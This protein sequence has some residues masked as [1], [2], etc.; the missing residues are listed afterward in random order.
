MSDEH[1]L[2]SISD[3]DLLRRLSEL[4]K[5]SRRVEAELIAHIAE[6][7]ARRLYAAH[8]SS[9]FSYCTEILHMAEHEAYLRIKA[10]RAS[11]EHPVLIEM[12]ADGRLHLSGIV[13][14][15][16]HLTEANRET[17][18]G[19]AV[20]KTRRQI[21]ELVAELFPKPDVPTTIRKLPERR[22]KTQPTQNEQQVPE[23]VE[24][25]NSETP[26]E[27]PDTG[28]NAEA[29]PAPPATPTVPPATRP[30]VV[31][32]LSKATYK[33]QFTASAKFRDKLERLQALMGSSGN[34]ADLA[35]V[36][37]AAVTEKLEKL[38]A[39]RY[40][41]TKSPRKSL[42]EA[43]TSPSSR[44]ISA[45]VRRAVYARDGGQC[46]YVDP[47]GRRC[48]ETKRLEFHHLEP[49]GKNGDRSVNNVELR[50]R[51]HNFLEAERDYG[52]KIMDR[53]RNSGG[54]VSEPAA[55]YT[56]SNRTTSEAGAAPTKPL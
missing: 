8:A 26:L 31:E 43:D 47:T 46:G 17:L 55:V 24:A 48:T 37:E 56:F 3:D 52:K 15:R 42:E 1:Q 39:K 40:G 49:Y 18:L 5:D 11:R 14:L 33:V 34:D 9:L 53:Y 54:R 38:E 41:K 22:E 19:R 10:A 25:Q 2:K 35:T 23:P 16:P 45:P 6:V 30:A 20:H 29:R 13:V 7:D 36:I 50:C 51:T 28:E 12:L 21:E 4:L 32:P 44:Y 27:T